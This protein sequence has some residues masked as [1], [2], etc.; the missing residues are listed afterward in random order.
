MAASY[1]ASGRDCSAP[2]GAVGRGASTRSESMD[3]TRDARPRPTAEHFASRGVCNVLAHMHIG[4]PYG[5]WMV[6]IAIL[7]SRCLIVTRIF[8]A[9]SAQL[10]FVRRDGQMAPGSFSA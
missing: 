6:E 9:A 1:A 7:C 5:K 4:T 8:P 2:G 10:F 3:A